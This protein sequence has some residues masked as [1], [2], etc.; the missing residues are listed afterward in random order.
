[1]NEALNLVIQ[2][3]NDRSATDMVKFIENVRARV[4][5]DQ[6]QEMKEAVYCMGQYRYVLVPWV[7]SRIID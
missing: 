2:E 3:A 1:M 4:F 7:F 5:D 6:L